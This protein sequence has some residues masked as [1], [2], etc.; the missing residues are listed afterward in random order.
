W[1]PTKYAG[2]IQGTPLR[3]APNLQEYVPNMLK[4]IEFSKDFK[5]LN[6]FLRKGMKWSDGKPHTADDWKFWY[7]DVLT[8][9]DI[10]PTP[11]SSL[12]A[13]GKLLTFTKLDDYSFRFE[14]AGPK[15]SFPLVNLA[16]VFGLWDDNALP[17]HYL[18]QF[19]LK[20]NPQA[21]DQA[22]AEKF[23]SWY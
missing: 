9:K 14:F 21:N 10:T 11:D 12:T 4:G 8:N 23:E 20:Y 16:H 7:E 1:S 5:V 3:M 22:K 18:K 15:P 19:H 13:G 6:M 2:A 17:A